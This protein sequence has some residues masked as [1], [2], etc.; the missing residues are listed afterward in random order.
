MRRRR[1]IQEP[2]LASSTADWEP[3]VRE[4][5]TDY[6]D[7]FVA[8]GEADLVADL[9]WEAPAIIALEFM[10]MAEEEVA[11]A[12][13]FA[14]GIMEWVFGKPTEEEQIASC[15]L[16]G[17]HMKHSRG[18]IERMLQDPSGPGRAATRCPCPSGGSGPDRH[19]LPRGNGDGGPRGRASDDELRLGERASTCC[20]PTR[21]AGMRSARTP[22]SFPAPSRSV[23]EPARRCSRWRR[24]A[25]EDV[26][27]GGVAIPEGGKILLVMGSGN[28]DE[29]R[30][31][32]AGDIRHPPVQRSTAPDLRDRR[33]L[34]PGR[35]ARPPGDPDLPRGA[36]SPATAHAPGRAG[37]R[38]HPDDLRAGA[39]RLARRVGRA[40]EPGR[41]RPS[42]RLVAEAQMH[43]GV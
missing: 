43:S 39:A 29:E 10:G 31:R 25:V 18:V 33:T 37:D 14:Q 23:C 35:A 21:R 16:M 34:L 22:P 38:D 27:V 41:R 1:R 28:H 5:F 12:K 15:D 4:V 17:R 2:F 3:R 9:F 11:Q 20:S 36:D 42:R 6:I 26:V 19:R 24:V 40:R 32:A 30:V 8:R 7:R 13:D